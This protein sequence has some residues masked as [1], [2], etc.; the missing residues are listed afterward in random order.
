MHKLILIKH[1]PIQASHGEQAVLFLL[2]LCNYAVYS[3]CS[4]VFLIGY[5]KRDALKLEN[6]AVRP[7]LPQ[8]VLDKR[9]SLY[10]VFEKAKNDGA[11][12]KFV[13]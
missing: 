2:T 8:E 1:K 9:K 7:Q 3:D 10:S 11:R 6:M 12:V 13:Y 5:D 4:A